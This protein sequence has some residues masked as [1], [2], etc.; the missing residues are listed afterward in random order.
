VFGRHDPLTGVDRDE[1]LIDAAD[2]AELGLVEGDRVTLRSETGS[3]TGRLHFARLPRRSL[4]V[5]WPEGNVV[6]PAGPEHR[7]D[8]SRVPDYNAVVTISPDRTAGSTGR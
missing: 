6:I 5:H 1:I 2:A 7:E 8:P 3:L 4:Q